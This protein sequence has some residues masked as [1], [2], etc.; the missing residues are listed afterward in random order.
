[1]ENLVL[2]ADDMLLG[3]D[4]VAEW[5]HEKVREQDL[6]KEWHDLDD[7]RFSQYQTCLLH[8]GRSQRKPGIA[9]PVVY[10]IGYILQQKREYYRLVSWAQIGNRYTDVPWSIFDLLGD[11]ANWTTV[12]GCGNSDLGCVSHNYGSSNCD[13]SS[14]PYFVVWKICRYTT[15]PSITS[16]H[17]YPQIS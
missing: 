13:R 7:V 8:F 10:D 1:M 2:K 12:K 6:W 5:Q 14:F 3:L 17:S 16:P 4:L 11:T 9:N 15:L